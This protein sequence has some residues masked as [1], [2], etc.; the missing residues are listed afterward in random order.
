MFAATS[1]QYF[2]LTPNQ[3]QPTATSQ[4]A[5][6]FSH[7]KSAPAISD[8]TA[9]RVIVTLP[10]V[11]KFIITKK[12]MDV[13]YAA[14]SLQSLVPSY[15]GNPELKEPALPAKSPRGLARFRRASISLC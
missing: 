6:F 12:L 7:N 1:Q 8:S 15:P 9:N 3:Y 2:S 10:F 4:P 5:V 13:V 14:R 11:K